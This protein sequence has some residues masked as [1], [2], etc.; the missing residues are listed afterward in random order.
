MQ[1]VLR[2]LAEAMIV[3]GEEGTEGVLGGIGDKRYNIQRLSILALL[4]SD[5]SQ[6]TLNDPLIR[7]IPK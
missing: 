5:S 3:D 4:G 2:R 6:Q 7:G 1:G